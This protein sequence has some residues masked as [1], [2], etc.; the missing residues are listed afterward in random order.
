MAQT[1]HSRIATKTR[2]RSRFPQAVGVK[3][4]FAVKAVT[5]SPVGFTVLPRVRGTV[6]SVHPNHEVGREADSGNLQCRFESLSD[7]PQG[8]Y[9]QSGSG[10]RRD[11]TVSV[12][13]VPDAQSGSTD[14]PTGR[15]ARSQ[16]RCLQIRPTNRW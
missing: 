7:Q 10:G 16:E 12:R 3:P 5:W 15:V 11:L 2:L 6:R 14:E 1:P 8:D 13:R 4:P 9:S